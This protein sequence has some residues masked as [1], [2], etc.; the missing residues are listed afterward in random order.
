MKSDGKRKPKL[1]QQLWGI[2]H[3]DR[4]D[5]RQVGDPLR[6]ILEAADK[7]IAEATAARLGFKYVW[8]KPVNAEDV[9]DAQWLPVRPRVQR[10]KLHRDGNE[11][12]QV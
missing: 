11:C 10:R 12:V 4:E 2:Y 6:T 9:K 1:R 5:A 7:V 8:A 3:A